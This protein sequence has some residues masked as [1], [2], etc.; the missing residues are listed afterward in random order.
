MPCLHTISVVGAVAS[1]TARHVSRAKF[2]LMAHTTCEEVRGRSCIRCAV[3]GRRRCRLLDN[4]VKRV[5][6]VAVVVSSS[7]VHRVV[8]VVVVVQTLLD[9]DGRRAGTPR[10]APAESSRQSSPE[11][12]LWDGSVHDS[13]VGNS[14]VCFKID[15]RSVLATV[16]RW[17][18]DPCD[19]TTAES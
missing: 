7:M 8:V 3:L 11:A 15:I 18:A 17:Y 14:R 19:A 5:R 16:D 6:V 10:R 13:G 4:L 1:M 2:S 9:D 12:W